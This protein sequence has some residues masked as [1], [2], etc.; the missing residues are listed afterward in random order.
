MHTSTRGIKFASGEPEAIR[1]VA[2]GAGTFASGSDI[3]L[4]SL[5]YNLLCIVKF[6]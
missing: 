3:F 6:S 1:L 2:S 5:F 4:R